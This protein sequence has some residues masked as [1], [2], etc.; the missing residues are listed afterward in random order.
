M[1]KLSWAKFHSRKLYFSLAVFGIATYCLF[2]GRADFSSW[3]EFIK[4]VLGIYLTA[5]V[6]EAVSN[7]ITGTPTAIPD[8]PQ[9][10]SK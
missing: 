3:S 9:V 5:N 10:S 4:W 1:R 7:G 2:S 8:P 6:G